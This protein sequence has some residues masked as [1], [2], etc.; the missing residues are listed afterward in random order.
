MPDEQRYAPPKPTID[1]TDHMISRALYSSIPIL[2]GAAVELFQYYFA[3]PLERRRDAWME[4]VGRALRNLEAKQGIRIKDLQNNDA[5]I[6]TVFHCFHLA[7]RNSEREKKEA[8][9][10]AV[11][12]AA[13]PAVDHSLQ[14]M[15]L[16]LIDTFTVW[17]LRILKLF[18]DPLDWYHQMGRSFPKVS[19]GPP[20]IVLED[21][22]PEIQS[23]KDFYTQIWRDMHQ[24]G[25]TNAS[26]LH[27]TMS[28]PGM[29]MKK[30]TELGDQFLAFISEP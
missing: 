17:H 7:M 30:T 10:N 29:I 8:L 27:G 14:Q 9:R 1:D 4:E 3:P 22:Y 2:G 11:I 18:Q 6:D 15:F 23:R 19:G 25:L 24:N 12:N 28:Y 20:S 21:A 16:N 5:F 26:T 13:I